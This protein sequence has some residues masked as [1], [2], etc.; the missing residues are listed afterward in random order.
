[1]SGKLL[2]LI[3]SCPFYRCSFCPSLLSLLPLLL[4]P[5][6]PIFQALLLLF[7]LPHPAILVMLS[8]SQR[9]ERLI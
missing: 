6:L 2:L 5:L 1:M 8:S 4:L 7:V 3:P 9:W